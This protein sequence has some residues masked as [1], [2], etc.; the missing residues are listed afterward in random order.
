[1]NDNQ[2]A[3]LRKNRISI[4]DEINS[5]T[6]LYVREALGIK[7]GEGSPPLMI[8][9]SS[10]GGQVVAG[11]DVYDLLKFYTGQKVGV[12][13]AMA[14]SMAA[15][16]LQACDWRVGTQHSRVLIHHVSNQ[17]IT[18]D[19]ARDPEKFGKFRDRMEASQQKLY[20][21]L[22]GRTGKSIEEIRATCELDTSMTAQEALGYCLIGQIVVQELE[23]KLPQ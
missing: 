16:I 3:L 11:L 8:H 10:N 13:Q 15:V 14:A 21:I 2:K 1:M 7:V 9:I 18:L 19:I 23:V 22:V 6:F 17:Y 20:Q 4:I 12:V 5:E